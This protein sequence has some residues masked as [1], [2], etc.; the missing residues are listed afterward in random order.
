MAPNQWQGLRRRILL[1]SGFRLFSIPCL[2]VASAARKRA[3][4]LA[5]SANRTTSRVALCSVLPE[6]HSC[7][8]LQARSAFSA[9]PSFR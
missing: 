6:G 8:A 3:L 4:A 7:A 5:G 1:G 2:S 9:C